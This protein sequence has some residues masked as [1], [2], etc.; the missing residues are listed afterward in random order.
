[1]GCCLRA[2]TCPTANS[3]APIC[4]SCGDRRGGRDGY[5]VLFTGPHGRC[6]KMLFSPRQA[7][8]VHLKSK[9]WF[10]PLPVEPTPFFFLGG[11][12][13]DTIRRQRL[14]LVREENLQPVQ[15]IRQ[16]L[17]RKGEMK[18]FGPGGARKPYFKAAWTPDTSSGELHRRVGIR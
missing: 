10:N 1:M 15:R 2:A 17:A 8:L 14:D 12:H 13:L 11:D 7:A 6:F 3:L 16:R 5:H 9:Q 18:P 4:P